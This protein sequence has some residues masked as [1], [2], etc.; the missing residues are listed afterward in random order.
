MDNIH[1]NRLDFT[2]MV[3]KQIGG[4]PQMKSVKPIFK[5]PERRTKKEEETFINRTNI[6]RNIDNIFAHVHAQLKG[7]RESN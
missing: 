2:K 6:Q 7:L 3:Y 1:T 4:Y 5:H